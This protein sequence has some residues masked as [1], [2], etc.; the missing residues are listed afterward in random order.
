[1]S[2]FSPVNRPVTLG[3]IAGAF[4]VSSARVDRIVLRYRIAPAC[5]IGRT[6]CYGPREVQRIHAILER[7]TPAN[8]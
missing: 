1:V 4:G 7:A 2:D 8:A 5:R 3:E 6:R